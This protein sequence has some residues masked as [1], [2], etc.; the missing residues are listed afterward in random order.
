MEKFYD[1]L[2]IGGGPGGYLCAERAAQGGFHTAII[3]KANLGGT[4]LNEGCVPTKSLLYCAKQY[5]SALHGKD[6]GFTAADVTYDHAAVIARKDRVV[7]KLVAGVGASMKG[8]KIDVY[9]GEGALKGR[10]PEKGYDVEVAGET[11]TAE[12]IVLA[13]GSV[14]A[15]PPI[16]GVKEGIASGFVVTSREFLNMKE[17]PKEMVAI[18]G[19]VIGLE[20][21]CYLATVGVKVTV[22]EMMPKIAGPTDAD[23]C[24]N[25]MKTYQKDY[26]MKFELSAKVKEVKTDCVVYEDK[27][28]K[29]VEAK[30]DKVLLAAG[31]R[32]N[33]AGL[34]VE[35]L[36]IETNRGAV[37]TDRYMLTNV[38]NIYAVGD[39]NGK[40]M[41]AHTAYRE[42]EVAVNHML[43]LKDEMNYD[44]IPS[45]IYTNPEVAS[46]GLSKKA[47]EEKGL[48]VTEVKV[49][50]Q[51]SGRYVAETLRGDGFAKI[52]YDT[53]HNRIVGICM[54]G[55]YA[56]EIIVSAVMMLDT[57]LPLS[58][59]KKIVFPHPTV[60]EVIREGLFML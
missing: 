60:G 35:A 5:S 51:M 17:L 33:I 16:P 23:I 45:V 52:V 13:T 22:V 57:E 53:E 48:K 24:D 21:A 56:S 44:T 43:G 2:V 27:D 15:V 10:N 32:A 29:T 36:G 59:L 37:V 20:M 47:A 50:M 25:L 11:I 6:Y 1:V 4:C 31:R 38:P 9:K 30:C 46:V 40:L 54:V 26:G 14:V 3:E 12:R 55:N 58:Q 39:C 8:N 28:G 19:G 7:K 41:L 49:P 42:A 18:G 34:N